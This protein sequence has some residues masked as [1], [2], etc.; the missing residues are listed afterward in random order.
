MKTLSEELKEDAFTLIK[1]LGIIVK[2]FFQ[3]ASLIGIIV[4]FTT[5]ALSVVL[6]V[7]LI[8]LGLKALVT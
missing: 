7:Y 5:G 2:W 4:I 3:I 1:A 8:F 6:I